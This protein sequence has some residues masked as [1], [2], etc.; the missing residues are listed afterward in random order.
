MVKEYGVLKQLFEQFIKERMKNRKRF[1]LD[2]LEKYLIKKSGGVRK[3]E[4]NGG[5][6]GLYQMLKQKSQQEYII[7]IKSSSFNNR[8]P[9][10]KSRWQLVDE[11]Y[12]G[13]SKELIFELSRYLDLTYYLKR[14]QFQTPELAE[15]LIRIK[16]FLQEKKNRKEASREERSLELFAD[17]KFLSGSAGKKLLNRLRLTLEDI[18]AEKYSQMFVYWQNG[19]GKI[20]NI[21]IL[22]NHSAFIACKRVLE[23]GYPL[24]GFVFDTLIFG[25]GK[26]I[27]DSLKFIREIAEPEEVNLKYAGDLDPEG[28]LIYN[29]LQEKYSDLNLTLFIEYYLMLLSSDRSYSLNKEQN[30]NKEIFNKFLKEFKKDN[31][32]HNTKNIQKLKNLWKFDLRIPQEVI[33]YE[34]LTE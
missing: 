30:K 23:E 25:S 21:L 7:P 1:N 16:N 20:K 34:S 29:C 8:I 22:E 6:Q 4:N 27:I 9:P 10:L 28:M 13:W 3:Y 19:Q 5:Y 26:H 15:K 24:Y 31:T 17:E 11:K 14:P 2:Q 18:K 33:T 32:K 12:Q